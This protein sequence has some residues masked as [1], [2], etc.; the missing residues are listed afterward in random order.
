MVFNIYLF[1]VDNHVAFLLNNVNIFN[2]IGIIIPIPISNTI[3]VS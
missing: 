1:T 2:V 3:I